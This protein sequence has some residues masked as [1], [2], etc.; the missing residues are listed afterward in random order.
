MTHFLFV[1]RSDKDTFDTMAPEVIQRFNQKWQTWIAEGHRRA[2]CSTQA[3][4]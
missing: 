1:H 2:G 4:P 3:T